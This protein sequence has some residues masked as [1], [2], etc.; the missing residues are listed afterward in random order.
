MQ[1]AAPSGGVTGGGV[2]LIGKVVGVAVA[3]VAEASQATIMIRGA[4]S[5]LPKATGTAWT[6][7]DMLYWDTVNSNLTKTATSNTF[8]GYAYADAASGDT[9]G[10]VLLSH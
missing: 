2:V 7:G 4:Y 3:D 9:T 6:A 5:D 1:I 8:A 10:S